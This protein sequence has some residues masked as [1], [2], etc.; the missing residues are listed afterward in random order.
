MSYRRSQWFD[1]IR[2]FLERTCCTARAFERRTV[3][4]GKAVRRAGR[5]QAAVAPDFLPSLALVFF[6][7]L[8]SENEM[9]GARSRV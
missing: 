8:M 5:C 3:A 9:P 4:K 2:G 7:S 6:T 1:E